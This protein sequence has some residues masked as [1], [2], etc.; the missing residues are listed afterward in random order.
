MRLPT[1]GAADDLAVAILDPPRARTARGGDWRGA[2]RGDLG[3]CTLLCEGP[4]VGERLLEPFDRDGG[5]RRSGSLDAFL[6]PACEVRDALDPTIG[7]GLSRGLDSTSSIS[8]DSSCALDLAEGIRRAR[9]LCD[10]AKYRVNFPASSPSILPGTLECTGLLRP[11]PTGLTF[12]A[13]CRSSHS[14]ASSGHASLT[15]Q[16]A[17]QILA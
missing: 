9:E 2:A 5:T 1:S 14:L 7:E 16:S 8:S 12:L 10:A 17:I 6:A 4:G 3:L 13:A 11:L 15:S